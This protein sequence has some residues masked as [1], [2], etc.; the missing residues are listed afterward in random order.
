MQ[1]AEL[2]EKSILEA[3]RTYS[4][5]HRGSGHKSMVSTRLFEECR[6]IVLDF[7]GVDPRKFRVIFCTPYQAELMAKVLKPGSHKTLSSLSFGLAV[8]VRALVVRK[9]GFP[10]GPPPMSGGGSAKLISTRWVIWERPPA[11]YEAG[12]PPLINIITFAR[13]LQLVKKHGEK[14]FEDLPKKKFSEGELIGKDQLNGFTG[15]ALLNRFRDTRI[16]LDLRVPTAKG[17]QR[18]INLDSSASTPAFGPVWDVFKN[19][20]HADMNS[21]TR[22]T[23]A[24]RK[25]CSDFL[26]APGKDYEIIF[27]SNTTEG[28]NLVAGSLARTETGGVEPLVLGTLL[29]H[30]SN[31]LPWRNVGNHALI[32]LPV[33]PE[34]FVDSNDLEGLLDDYNRKG[35]YGKQR[36][37]LVAISAASNVLGT[38]NNIHEISEI[39]HRYDARLLVDG[40]QLVSHRK[41]DI[42]RDGID[43]FVFSAHKVYAPFGSG[44]LVVKKGILNYSTRDRDKIKS[45]GEENLAGI[46]AMGKALHVLGRIGMDLIEREEQELTRHALS[47]MQEIPGMKLVGIRAYDAAKLAQRVGVIPFNLGNMVSFTLGRKLASDHGI[48]VRVGC[49]CAHILVKHVLGVKPGLE[50]FQRIMQKLI[51]AMTFPGV[52]RVSFGL[53]NTMEDVDALLSGLKSMAEGGGKDAG[54]ASRSQIRKS[55]KDYSAGCRDKVFGLL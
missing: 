34:G 17:P 50:R 8:G 44:A 52:V 51:P 45:C 33:D 4:N 21:G 18:F 48:G 15:Q 11:K 35:K 12:T 14:L 3:L 6:H 2:L 37:R 47:G 16:G 13:T 39:V 28:I 26:G 55:I 27:T 49:H 46:A 24:V 19:T 9:G 23:A 5:V 1:P 31:D 41:V 40:A 7:L 43:F 38:C 53:E 42:G 22:I 36:I 32:H 54:A 10:T 25:I 29:E 20:L 30:S